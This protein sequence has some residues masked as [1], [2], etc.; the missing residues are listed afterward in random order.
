MFLGHVD[1]AKF[2]LKHNDI[3]IALRDYVSLRDVLNYHTD[4]HIVCLL[5]M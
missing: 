5:G 3:L 2:Y 1:D 4:D